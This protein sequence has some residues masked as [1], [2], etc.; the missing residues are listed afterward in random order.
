MYDDKGTWVIVV[1]EDGSGGNSMCREVRQAIADKMYSG[2]GVFEETR[3]NVQSITRGQVLEI[4]EV[5]PN[6]PLQSL[7]VLSK[8]EF[9]QKKKIPTPPP[10]FNNRF[11]SSSLIE[12]KPEQFIG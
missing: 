11:S 1:I 6:R 8:D 4:C 12:L 10:V 2:R 7:K 5:E 9:S 3:V